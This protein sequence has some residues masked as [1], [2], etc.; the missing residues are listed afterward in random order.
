[1]FRKCQIVYCTFLIPIL[2]LACESPQ[3]D[4]SNFEISEIVVL[5]PNFNR[6]RVI[7]SVDKLQKIAEQIQIDELPVKAQLP[8]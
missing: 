6:E 5:Y 4:L 8:G 3:V 2:I 1:M 7:T